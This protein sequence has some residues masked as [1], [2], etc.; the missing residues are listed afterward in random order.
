MINSNSNRKAKAKQNSNM[1]DRYDTEKK[2][3]KENMD[4]FGA[5]R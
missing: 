4:Q 1:E 3:Q 5:I 2:I